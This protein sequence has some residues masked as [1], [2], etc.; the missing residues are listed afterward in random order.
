MPDE[1]YLL[2]WAPDIT[3]DADGNHQ[4]EFFTSD[5]SGTYQVVVEGL[6]AEGYSGSRTF[7]F[8]V[9]PAENP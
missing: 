5:V 8:T 6:T 9:T 3:T 4:L 7:T 1:R 2:H